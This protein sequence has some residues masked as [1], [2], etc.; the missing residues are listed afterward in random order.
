MH[1]SRILKKYQEQIRQKGLDREETGMPGPNTATLHAAGLACFPGASGQAILALPSF[2]VL[3]LKCLMQ[4]RGF[5]RVIRPIVFTPGNYFR[6]IN[7]RT[8]DT[9]CREDASC[10]FAGPTPLW[11][12]HLGSSLSVG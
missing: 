11:K 5:L 9:G 4:F 2:P 10:C 7:S 1:T 8:Q 6:V 3:D 12:Q